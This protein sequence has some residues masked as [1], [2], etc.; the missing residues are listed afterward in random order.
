[1]T[2]EKRLVILVRRDL[3]W[4]VRCV[5]SAHA[6][7]AWTRQANLNAEEWSQY[8]PAFVLYGVSGVEEL[9]AWASKLGKE[10]VM[11]CEPDLGGEATALAYYGAGQLE[12]L[13]LL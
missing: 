11:F 4:N 5:Q 9:E 6:V 12:G 1:M 2:E 10:C 3:P 13:Y 8:G 7:A